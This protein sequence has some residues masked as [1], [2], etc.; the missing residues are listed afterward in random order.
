MVRM[1]SPGIHFLLTLISGYAE[2]RMTRGEFKSAF[3]TETHLNVQD[4][5]IL[6]CLAVS[7]YSSSTSQ[8]IMHFTLTLLSC[9]HEY[10]C[11]LQNK[12]QAFIRYMY[13][14]GLANGPLDTLDLLIFC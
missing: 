11:I 10:L 3:V 1:K 8:Y 6:I 4:C 5:I 13:F 12:R 9:F 7:V 2:S 14:F